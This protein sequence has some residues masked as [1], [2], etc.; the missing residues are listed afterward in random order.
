MSKEITNW[1]AKLYPAQ[2]FQKDTDFHG[3]EF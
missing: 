2:I 3:S 1:A